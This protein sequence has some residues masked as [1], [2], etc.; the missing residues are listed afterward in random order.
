MK[1]GYLLGVFLLMIASSRAQKIYGLQAEAIGDYVVVYYD[2]E[3]TLEGQW[4]KVELYSSHNQFSEP[5]HQVRGD[6]GSGV[7]AGKRKKIEWGAQKELGNYKGELIFE[8]KAQ[9]VFSPIVLQ[10][11]QARD[12]YR[13]SKSYLL[14]WKGGVA[15]E[16]LRLELLREGTSTKLIAEVPNTGSYTWQIPGGMPVGN[17]YRL[18]I[19]SLTGQAVQ[20]SEPFT[21]KRRVP[22]GLKFIPLGLV[23][24]AGL[25][26]LG[27]NSGGGGEAPVP[28]P[29]V[30]PPD[31]TK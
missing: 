28:D 26:I 13:R 17:N 7:T 25:V 15:G 31:H 18:R 10:H 30:G 4:F 6:A 2:L 16:K 3:G 21:I 23:A 27:R 11:P 22:N 24:G 1:Y 5:L 19:S 20:T 14:N 8:I 12:K 9:L 29:L